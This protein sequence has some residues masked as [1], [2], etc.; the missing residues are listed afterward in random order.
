MAPSLHHGKLFSASHV[1]RIDGEHHGSDDRGRSESSDSFANEVKESEEVA[2]RKRNDKDEEEGLREA[3]ED[4]EEEEK[5]LTMKE[6]RERRA[7]RKR[8]EDQEKHGVT[9]QSI[10]KLRS[11]ETSEASRNSTSSHVEGEPL[12]GRTSGGK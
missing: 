12:G 2:R 8:G 7:A 4:A 1:T 3:D 11:R 9:M 5:V 10:D 6:V